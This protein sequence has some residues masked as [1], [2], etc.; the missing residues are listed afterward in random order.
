[1]GTTARETQLPVIH[2]IS[3]TINFDTAGIAAGVLVGTLP[4]GAILDKTMVQ[5][6]TAFNGTVTVTLSVGTTATGTDLI[7]A[8]DVRTAA[9][10]VDTVVPI[11][12]A[13]PLAAS[14][15][16]YASLAFGGTVGTAGLANVVVT[17]VP[18]V[19]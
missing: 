19:G 6:S 4:A 11:A 12:K 16:I 2:Q 3:R 10:R 13:G 5:T 14:T 17:Y 7:N 8:T 18:D 15:P 9:A 1:M